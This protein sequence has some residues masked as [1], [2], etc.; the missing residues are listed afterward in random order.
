M[1]T[2][3]KTLS[4]LLCLVFALSMMTAAISVQAASPIAKAIDKQPLAAAMTKA[5]IIPAFY[6]VETFVPYATA[7]A[8]AEATLANT[9]ATVDEVNAA[10]TALLTARANLQIVTGPMRFLFKFLDALIEMFWGFFGF[11]RPVIPAD[12]PGPPETVVTFTDGNQYPNGDPIFIGN[13]STIV[14]NSDGTLSIKGSTYSYLRDT[15]TPKVT[16]MPE[17]GFTVE[18]KFYLDPATMTTGQGFMVTT[19]L[20]GNDAAHLVDNM[21]HL[22][23]LSD[24]K[25]WA[26]SN[27]NSDGTIEYNASQGVALTESGTGWYTLRY[28]FEPLAS[29][30]VQLTRQIVAP[31]GNVAFSTSAPLMVNPTTPMTLDQA[32]GIG[33][34]QYFWFPKFNMTELKV[35]SVKVIGL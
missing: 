6:T 17:T 14:E 34:I 30:Q 8:T 16:E 19:A 27:S 29:K 2:A 4:L 7:L 35:E 5:P 13:S 22:A 11:T 23:K 25:L 32:R 28:V 18:M 9:R 3:K 15:A 20:C 1:K 21:I 26:R 24:G 31:S 10:T 12:P 33:G